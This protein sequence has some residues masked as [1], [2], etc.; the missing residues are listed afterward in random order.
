MPPGWRRRPRLNGQ[1]A[2]ARAPSFD[3]LAIGGPL[4]AAF[5]GLMLADVKPGSGGAVDEHQTEAG[6]VRSSP[7][8]ETAIGSDQARSAAVAELNAAAHGPAAG[9]GAGTTEQLTP[10]PATVA[11]DPLPAEAHAAATALDVPAPATGVS[12]AVDAKA[13]LVA[14]ATLSMTSISLNLD[15]LGEGSA[16]SA[17]HPGSIGAVITGSAGNDVIQGTEGDDHLSGGAG[18]DV[19]LGYGR[20]RRPPERRHR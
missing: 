8:G 18:N 12:A 3:S 7:G 5:V 2:A 1:N 16:D 20:W 15:P 6:A 9:D 4:T 11:G 13:T 19:I 14:G 17:G 10:D